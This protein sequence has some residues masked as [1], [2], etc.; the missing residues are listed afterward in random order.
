MGMPPT[1]HPGAGPST[2]SQRRVTPWVSCQTRLPVLCR[3]PKAS[4]PT[5]DVQ[6]RVPAPRSPHQQQQTGNQGGDE[7]PQQSGEPESSRIN[8]TDELDV[9]GL[10]GSLLDCQ[11]G[12]GAGQESYSEKQV[13]NKVV[14]FKAAAKGPAFTGAVC[15]HGGRQTR[16]NRRPRETR[17][18]RDGFAGAGQAHL[19][20]QDVLRGF[21]VR[22]GLRVVG[23]R[24]G[25][26]G[27]REQLEEEVVHQRQRHGRGVVRLVL[28][29]AVTVVWFPSSSKEAAT[30]Y[31][32]SKPSG[33]SSAFSRRRSSTES[34]TEQG[35]PDPHTLDPSPAPPE[36]LPTALPPTLDSGL[37]WTRLA[38]PFPAPA[39]RAASCLGPQP[40][41]S[42]KL[43]C[44]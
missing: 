1:R 40:R 33:S 37:L 34:A 23:S 44:N 18:G 30:T 4:P 8:A 7:V 17:W 21:Q 13:D 41:A 39:C 16:R 15:N 27:P 24:D 38:L 5:Q 12:K 10:R 36:R 31:L 25:S 29:S 20:V 14:S 35:T 6:G 28:N 19:L 42:I 26:R 2:E 3:L 9:L 43:P 22:P 11:D 32:K